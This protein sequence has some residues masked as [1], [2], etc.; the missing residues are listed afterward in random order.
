MIQGR[1]TLLLGEAS[2]MLA[3]LE[4]N[5]V[6][7]I[8]TDPPSGASM[9]T[10]FEERDHENRYLDFDSPLGRLRHGF[11]TQHAITLRLRECFQRDVWPVLRQSARLLKP[12]GYG[13]FWAFQKT[14]HWL[15][16][17]LEESG[18]TVMD[19]IVAAV[20]ERR[21]KTPT[22]KGQSLQIRSETDLWLLARKAGS[23]DTSSKN[24]ARWGTGYMNVL[25]PGGQTWS[26]LC[27]TLSGQRE[28]EHPTEKTVEQMR[29]FVRLVTPIDG[30]VL[31]PFMGTGTT[32]VAAL[33]EGYGFLGV[34]RNPKW[35]EDAVRRTAGVTP[36]P[37]ESVGQALTIEECMAL[38]E[39]E[40]K[41]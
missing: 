38:L 36:N 5:S 18:M 27:V 9:M 28:T 20:P 4:G 40:G 37:T 17:G 21:P 12:G 29:E 8:V 11:K 14:Q 6:D 10:P 22:V 34:E 1:A 7:A 16:W 25:R 31:D 3:E 39:A 41:L 2:N 35:Y 24:R 30:T 19:V 13:L 26:N 33:L 32:G 15:A 23:E